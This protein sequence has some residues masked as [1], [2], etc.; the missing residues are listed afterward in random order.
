MD[1]LA[2]VA[3]STALA[4]DVG[5]G[6]GQLS[7]LLGERFERVIATDASA[8][9]LEHAE[10]HPRVEYRLGSAEASGLDA[11]SV[12]VITAAQAAHWFDLPRFYAEVRRVARAPESVVALVTYSFHTVAPAID[13]VVGRFALG[14]VAAYWP[15]ERAHVDAG[16]ASLG[17]PFARLE[18]PPLELTEDWSVDAMLGYIRTW[19]AVSAFTRAGHEAEVLAFEAEVRAAWGAIGTRRITWPLTVLAGRV[20]AP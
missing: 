10:P 9:Q 5:C 14:T 11:G 16:Y 20:G 3:P 6:S 13:E 4:W 12:D 7:T 2:S 17:F 19:S 18:V 8:Q 1:F 15:K